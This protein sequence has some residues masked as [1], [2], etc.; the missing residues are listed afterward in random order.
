MS[1]RNLRRGSLPRNILSLIQ[2]RFRRLE[3]CVRS[4]LRDFDVFCA[5]RTA[6][7]A[8]VAGA[9]WIALR[10][11]LTSLPVYRELGEHIP[12]NFMLYLLRHPAEVDDMVTEGT[13]RSRKL[14]R[15]QTDLREL[16]ASI[17]HFIHTAQKLL[18][19]EY[20]S[21]P[22]RNASVYAEIYQRCLAKRIWDYQWRE[23]VVD[24]EADELTEEEQLRMRDGLEE[25]AARD[26][27]PDAFELRITYRVARR[28]GESVFV[29]EMAFRRLMDFLC[30][31]L[32]RGLATG[33][34]PRRC[35]HCHRFF[36]LV[37]GHDT[38]YCN[39]VAPGE[40]KKTCRQIG[41]HRKETELNGKPGIRQEYARAYNR[42]KGRKSRGSIT[43]DEW[44]RQVKRIQDIKGDAEDGKLSD[45]EMIRLFAEI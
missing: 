43:A 25:E 30:L 7:A 26:E 19:E 17:E 9:S 6:S 32:L 21:P 18:D 5:A 22:K 38:R 31:D 29:E 39:R 3:D 42:L 20:S 45:A 8:A 41:A 23:A 4:F 36:L 37:D 27:F 12:G 2:V 1:G 35:D 13:T 15:W 11:H 10:D 16:P 34:L 44:N 14:R 28:K 40:R 33:H 24:F